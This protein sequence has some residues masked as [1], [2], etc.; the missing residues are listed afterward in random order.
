M[1]GAFFPQSCSVTTRVRFLGLSRTPMWT[2]GP[3]RPAAQHRQVTENGQFTI[4]T[5][6]PAQ[7]P[8]RRCITT[9]KHPGT[10]EGRSRERDSPRALQAVVLSAPRLT[11]RSSA[12]KKCNA[13]NDQCR[14][15]RLRCPASLNPGSGYL[16]GWCMVGRRVGRRHI[17]SLL[18]YLFPCLRPE[19]SALLRG[20]LSPARRSERASWESMPQ[21]TAIQRTAARRTM[22]IR[23]RDCI[24]VLHGATRCAA[25]RGRP[26]SVG[27]SSGRPV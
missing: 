27:R 14:S 19:A 7:P 11:S 12:T 18:R 21:T 22:Q 6:D 26:G 5:G 9:W 20:A 17:L 13:E 4:A 1:G 2:T 8:A 3:S 24:S 10:Y 25:E 15:H 23:V 16:I